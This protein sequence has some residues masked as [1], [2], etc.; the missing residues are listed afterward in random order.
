MAFES[1]KLVLLHWMDLSFQFTKEHFVW[2]Y[3]VLDQL[4]LMLA[5]LSRLMSGYISADGL[6]QC[7]R[8]VKPLELYEFQACP[9]CRR[10]RET[11]HYLAIDYICYPTP[12]ESLKSQ[13]VFINSR[14]RPAV[15][16]LGGKCQFPFL[17]DKNVFDNAVEFDPK[18][19][20]IIK[21]NTRD[22]A[23][24][25]YESGDINA[26]LW[27]VYGDKAVPSLRWRIIQSEWFDSVSRVI[28]MIA[29]PCLDMG[30]FR[31]ASRQPEKPLQFW[32]TE[33]SAPCARVLET[34]ATLELPYHCHPMPQGY[35]PVRKAFAKE[36]ADKI[37]G[38]RKSVGFVKQPFLRDPNTGIDMF[39][40]RDIVQ[41]LKKTYQTAPVPGER[42]ITS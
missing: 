1:W 16:T 21:N 28:T 7:R 18:V 42:W 10:V 25:L 11:L 12:K 36:H 33:G 3:L 41:Y 34:L 32:G 26:Y 17:V 24:M 8:P 30:V 5:S 4:T 29:R 13:G 31:A 2:G 6:E 37:S 27:A 23:V 22:G 39:E 20:A 9:Y 14:F 35:A 19:S 38:W 40:S 15:K